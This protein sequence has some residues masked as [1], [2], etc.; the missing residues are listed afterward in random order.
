MKRSILICFV[1]AMGLL[2]FTLASDID[3][4]WKTKMQGPD[5]EMDMVF[6]FKVLNGDTLT[7]TVKG[8]M[9]DVEIINGK[10]NG[11]DF[12]FDVDVNGMTIQHQCKL[13][14]GSIL[15]KV[16]GMPGGDME[17][18]LTRIKEE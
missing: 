2:S 13:Q 11:N 15:M 14:N 10:V 8:P 16:P 3:G 18:T 4:K 6:V 12:T 1:L 9:G 17:L 5:G 7:G